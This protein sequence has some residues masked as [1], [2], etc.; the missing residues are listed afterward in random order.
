MWELVIIFGISWAGA[1]GQRT[2]EMPDKQTCIM[3]LDH[4]K[5][6]INGSYATAQDG[7]VVI[8]FC[9]PKKGTK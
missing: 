1:G 7:D 6:N 4:A 3:A 2:N 5:I 8:A 9:R